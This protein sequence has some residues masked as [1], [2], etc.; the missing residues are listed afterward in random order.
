[1]TAFS[2]AP[3]MTGSSRYNA[4]RIAKGPRIGPGFI[5]SSEIGEVQIG[6][7]EMACCS[8]I[9][10][11]GRGRPHSRGAGGQLGR[12][13]LRSSGIARVWPLGWPRC[14]LAGLSGGGRDAAWRRR[15][16]KH[17]SKTPGR[18]EL[19]RKARMSDNVLRREC[20][21]AGFPWWILGIESFISEWLL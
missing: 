4:I 12:L 15:Y 8:Q 13:R 1:M 3:A 20:P 16:R 9:E 19:A 17:D 11:D 10:Q 2:L 14:T 6:A 5:T 18:E 21:W 7:A